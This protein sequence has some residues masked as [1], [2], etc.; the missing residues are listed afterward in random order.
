MVR[1]DDDERERGR[2]VGLE[3]LTEANYNKASASPSS[4]ILKRHCSESRQGLNKM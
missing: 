4:G 3:G 1:R 2:L